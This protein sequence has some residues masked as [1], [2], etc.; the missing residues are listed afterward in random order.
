[1]KKI[2]EA[3][4]K[5]KL[6]KHYGSGDV[7]RDLVKNKRADD[8]GGTVGSVVYSLR[9]SPPKGYA[10]VMPD[11]RRVCLYDHKGKRF[12]DMRETVVKELYEEEEKIQDF[13]TE[14]ERTK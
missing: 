4:L 8:H 6:L 7:D 9:G 3:E 11:I 1:M 2:T 10:I 13:L 5:E 14:L 12:R